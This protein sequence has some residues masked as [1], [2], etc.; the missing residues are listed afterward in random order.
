M[1]ILYASNLFD[2]DKQ[3]FLRYLF[4]KYSSKINI[5]SKKSTLEEFARGDDKKVI[6]FLTSSQQRFCKRG[7]EKIFL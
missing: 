5:N 1:N 3:I 7:M 6:Q 2:R 4:Q